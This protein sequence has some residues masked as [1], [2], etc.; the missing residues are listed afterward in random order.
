MAV[1]VSSRLGVYTWSSGNDPFTREQMDESHSS[2]EDRVATFLSGNIGERPAVTSA[3][4]RMFYLALD[5]NLPT[6]MLYYCDG[7]DW[8]TLNDIEFAAP[9]SIDPADTQSAGS[10]STFARSDHQHAMFPWGEQADVAAV[11]TTAA[12]GAANK[13]ARADH[14]H[15][16]ANN[17][18]TAGKIATGGVSASTQFA[19]GVVGSD[20][21][22][23][24]AVT[25]SKIAETERMPIG[26]IIQFGGSTAPAGWLLCD[27][28]AYSTTAYAALYAVIGTT[29]GF[30]GSDFKVPDM[31]GRVPVGQGTR[32]G[33]GATYSR[34]DIGG[35]E[36]V[37][38]NLNELP[39][40]T[41]GMTHNHTA[42][43]SADAGHTHNIPSR[44][45]IGTGT[46]TFGV[47]MFVALAEYAYTTATSGAHGH[48]ITVDNSAKTATDSAG[49]GTAHENRQPFLAV[50]YIIK[51]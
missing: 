12:A 19:A 32:S 27:G 10:A 37:T 46:N 4:D 1:Q 23:A 11:S 16:L 36:G 7:S 17:S 26:S 51:F 44:V 22:A 28:S 39:S 5:E 3:T 8:Y 33:G 31:S 9:V 20:A 2:M 25:R 48:T 47:G 24:D 6:G 45:G 35:S 43:A 14:V 40:H 30:S 41:H 13:Y 42:T 21:I 50:N 38:L 15:I 34:G 18:V 49:S 29:Y